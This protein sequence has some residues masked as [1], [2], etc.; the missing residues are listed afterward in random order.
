MAYAKKSRTQ[1]K[2]GGGPFVPIQHRFLKSRTLA[3][4]SPFAAKLLLDLLAFYSGHNNGDLCCTWALMRPRGWKSKATLEKARRE[5]LNKGVITLTRQGG[6]KW[7]SLHAL[8]LFWID[9]CRGKRLEVEPTTSPPNQWLL[10]EPPPSIA[11]AQA[12][13]KARQKQQAGS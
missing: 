12:A 7:P 1:R 5:L 3:G 6:R 10:H 8:D 11:E 4:L 9:E 13:F 2:W